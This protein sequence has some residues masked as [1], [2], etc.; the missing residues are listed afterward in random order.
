MLFLFFVQDVTHIDRGYRPRI[1]I[2]V[3]DCDLSL[4]GFQVI[5]YGRFW[6]FTKGHR[7]RALRIQSGSYRGWRVVKL[8]KQGVLFKETE[9]V[10]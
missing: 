4:A 10:N 5:I 9:E 1:A 3:L 7:L 6:V 8:T 2:N